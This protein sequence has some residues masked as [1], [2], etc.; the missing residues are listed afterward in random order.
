MTSDQV[1]TNGALRAGAQLGLT[2][3]ELAQVLHLDAQAISAMEA[4]IEP[5]RADT[6]PGQRAI[7]LI[8]ILHA[9]AVNVGLDEE[10]AKRWMASHNTALAGTPASLM[11]TD[12][13]LGAVLAYLQRAEA[14]QGA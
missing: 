4:G 3:A 8:K 11:Q 1:L 13:G 12:E 7:T 14:P 9:L 5:L 2:H 10:T 6:P